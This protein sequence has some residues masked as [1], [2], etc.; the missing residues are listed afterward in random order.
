M[1]TQSL[2]A[3]G[4]ANLAASD[5]GTS[6]T[7]Y[8]TLGLAAGGGSSPYLFAGTPNGYNEQNRVDSLGGIKIAQNHFAFAFGG[9]DRPGGAFVGA[10]LELNAYAGGTNNK[11]AV[12]ASSW[13][14][15]SLNPLADWGVRTDTLYGQATV[16]VTTANSP[17]S[18][19][20]SAQAL[21]DINAAYDAGEYW[22]ICLMDEDTYAN[23]TVADSSNNIG[24]LETLSN[25]GAVLYLD[26]NEGGLVLS[27]NF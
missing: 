19:S 9:T 21:T 4:T 8:S 14:S 11:M 2:T 15:G 5:T 13:V 16:D 24:Y 10:R 18:I 25:Q 17:V 6:A 22:S 3:H 27:H 26:T 20:L 7:R 1:A 12:L 23:V